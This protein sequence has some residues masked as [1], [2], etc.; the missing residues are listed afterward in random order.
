MSLWPTGRST[1]SSHFRPTRTRTET[2]MIISGPYHDVTPVAFTKLFHQ[3][4]IAIKQDE[5]TKF[6][7]KRTKLKHPP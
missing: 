7:L 2:I 4:L 1:T 6:S 5:I 3:H